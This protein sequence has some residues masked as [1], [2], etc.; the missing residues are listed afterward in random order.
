MLLMSCET[1]ADS[2]WMTVLAAAGVVASV[3]I[4]AGF[5]TELVDVV[6]QWAHAVRE[7]F[8]VQAQMAV[9]SAPVPI[10]VVD[11]HIEI[12]R[13]LQPVLMHGDGLSLD[14][15]LVD[16]EG[17]SVPRTPAHR[18]GPLGNSDHCKACQYRQKH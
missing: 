11:V 17:K 9:L 6:H 16:V 2:P 7:Q 8:G 4:D 10:T 1:H 12:A 13:F 3:G 14:E 15:V 18:G 5:Q